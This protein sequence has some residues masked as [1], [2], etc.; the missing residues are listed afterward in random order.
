MIIIPY[1]IIL[2]VVI[3]LFLIG[4]PALVY[5]G[6]SRFDERWIALGLLIM[7]VVRSAFSPKDNKYRTWGLISVGAIIMVL[8]S[9]FRDPIFLRLYPVLMTTVFLGVFFSSLFFPPSVIETF[10]RLGFKDKEMPKYV[11]EYTRNVTKVWCLFFVFNGVVSIYT[12]FASL[13]VWTLYNGLISYLLMGG[14]V[15]SEVTY[16]YLIIKKRETSK[17]GG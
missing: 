4:Y 13:E 10:A 16:R 9:I 2:R 8:V 3:F 17:E 7:I 12:V 6:L 14:L 11:V 5:F 1:K 15:A